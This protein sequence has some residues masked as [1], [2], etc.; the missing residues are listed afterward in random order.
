M[1][2]SAVVRSS[3]RVNRG[4]VIVTDI[5]EEKG[6]PRALLKE[7]MAEMPD[8]GFE[9]IFAELK[10]RVER[11]PLDYRTPL[12]EYWFEHEIESVGEEIKE[13]KRK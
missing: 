2:Q 10:R 1:V 6:D 5:P 4:E 8:A 11:S 3:R 13:E 12:W 9:E 7:I